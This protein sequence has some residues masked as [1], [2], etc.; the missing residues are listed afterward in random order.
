MRGGG[1]RRDG[2]RTPR[3]DGRAPARRRRGGHPHAALPLAQ[4]AEAHELSETGRA[5]GK[6][7]LVV[8]NAHEPSRRGSDLSHRS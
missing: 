4:A 6:I 8:Q 5:R 7:V 3:R 2:A 1:H